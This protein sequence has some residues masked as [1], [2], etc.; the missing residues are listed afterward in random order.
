M[1]FLQPPYGLFAPDVDLVVNLPAL[2]KLREKFPS[3]I[4]RAE[5]AQAMARKFAINHILPRSLETDKKCSQDP[6]YFDWDLWHAA[7]R[8]KFT[9]ACLPEKLG[10]LGWSALDNAAALEEFTSACMASTANFVFNVFGLL[11][12]MVEC[13]TGI[14]LDMVKKMAKAQQEDKPLFY[15]WAITEPGAGTDMEDACAM[16]TMRPSCHAQRVPGGYSLSGVKCFIT[17]GSMAHYVIVNM[18]TDQERPLETMATFHVPTNAKGFFVGRVE[19]KCGQKASQTAEIFFDKVFVPE[20]EMWEPPGKGFDHTREILSITRGLVGISAMGIARGALERCI[21]YAANKKTANGRLIDQDWVRF[22]IAD[23]LKDLHMVRAAGYNF[24]IALDTFHVWK[25]FDTAVVKG[26]TL[27]PGKIL[28]A[29]SLAA[30]ANNQLANEAGTRFKKKIVTN[31]VL[32]SFV[33]H[34]SAL[35]A[36]GSDLAMKVSSRVLDIV[37][38]DGMAREFGMEKCF[39]DAKVTQIYEGSNQANLWDFFH[40][41][42]GRLV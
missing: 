10:G 20:K 8:A 30:L 19:R 11:G 4:F 3:Y 9:V 24:A 28:M 2:G 25:I 35:K 5:K 16:Q 32:D 27:L 34:G 12:S 31:E 17:N 21:R 7:N 29:D 26:A 18:P 33:K 13:K 15:S 39:R 42:V 23:M 1:D 40:E 14:V 41:E 6:T 22:A 38:L 37:G 36:A